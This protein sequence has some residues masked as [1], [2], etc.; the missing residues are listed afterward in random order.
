MR[1]KS[2]LLSALERDGWTVNRHE[3]EGT[4][5]AWFQEVWE[6]ESRWSPHGFKLFLTF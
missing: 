1:I 3:G 6:I 2:E 4:H 5:L